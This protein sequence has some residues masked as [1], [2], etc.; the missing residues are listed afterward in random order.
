MITSRSRPRVCQQFKLELSE[1][2]S[3]VAELTAEESWPKGWKAEWLRKT[4][5]PADHL[6]ETDGVQLYATIADWVM[7]ECREE[8]RLHH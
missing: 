6:I 5:A 8:C 2:C 3:A 7:R 1:D 4:R